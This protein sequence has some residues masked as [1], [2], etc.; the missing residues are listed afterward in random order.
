MKDTS[1]LIK[2]LELNDISKKVIFEVLK[3]K[4]IAE[5]QDWEMSDY[6]AMDGYFFVTFAIKNK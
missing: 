6:D 5:E 2:G 4:A 1:Q 3:L